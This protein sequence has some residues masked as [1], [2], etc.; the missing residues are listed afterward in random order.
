MFCQS[1]DI[2]QVLGFLLVTRVIPQTLKPKQQMPW[3]EAHI[4]ELEAKQHLKVKEGR[5]SD[6]ELVSKAETQLVTKFSL[7]L[8][9]F[10]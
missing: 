7:R 4:E 9:N 1:G 10:C 5:H 8:T 3:L 6:S 2:L